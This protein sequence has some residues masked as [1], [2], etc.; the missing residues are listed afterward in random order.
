MTSAKTIIKHVSLLLDIQPQRSLPPLSSRVY[1]DLLHLNEF[2]I[3]P[4]LYYILESIMNFS[5]TNSNFK[6]NLM[7]LFLICDYDEKRERFYKTSGYWI[8]K[9]KHPETKESFLGFLLR[10]LPIS[11]VIFNFSIPPISQLQLQ[12][13][14][15]IV[16]PLNILAFLHA[17]CSKNDFQK[18]KYYKNLYAPRIF[19]FICSETLNKSWSRGWRLLAD[20]TE[21]ISYIHSK[22]IDLLYRKLLISARCK[23]TSKNNYSQ[24]EIALLY[25]IANLSKH[26][27]F[28]Q[29][30]NE[31]QE[32][33]Q[34]LLSL[35][36]ISCPI[37]R[38]Q[39]QR[40]FVNIPLYTK[41]QMVIPIEPPSLKTSCKH[42]LLKRDKHEPL[43]FLHSLKHFAKTK[44]ISPLD[45]FE[46]DN[47]DQSVGIS[48][49]VKYI[50]Q[51]ND[52]LH[53][54][55]LSLKSIS[56]S[57]VNIQNSIDID[58]NY[59]LSLIIHKLKKIYS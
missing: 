6:Q 42:S 28:D 46:V 25:V 18:Y 3:P 38:E 26:I 45:I 22:Y 15:S 56:K 41:H 9:Y 32:C 27:G 43:L 8:M 47:I 20:I 29:L 10:K 48:A 1:N 17:S 58:M 57:D 31:Y 55:N 16:L 37:T 30:E 34:H 50:S 11:G 39:V 4:E 12:E 44:N 54:W 19:N 7:V 5:G 23:L 2:N 52:E 35:I 49:A 36:S 14:I 51:Q 53:L 13:R 24:E 33:I 21:N 40:L 59:V